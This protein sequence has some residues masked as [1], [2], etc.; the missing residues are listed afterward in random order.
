MLKMGW[1][2]G[3]LLSGV[4]ARVVTL[5]EAKGRGNGNVVE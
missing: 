3:K 4:L 1:G 2:E 5:Q